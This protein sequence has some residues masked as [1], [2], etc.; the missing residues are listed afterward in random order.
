[1]SEQILFNKAKGV[2]RL[3]I[4]RPEVKNALSFAMCNE[5]VEIIGELQSDR[6]IRVLVLNAKGPDFTAGADLKDMS[7]A[8]PDD[9]Q[10]RGKMV[11]GKAREMAWPIFIGLHNIRQPI[12]ASVR[13]H[14][15]GAGAQFILSADLTVASQTL[16]LA[17]PQVNLAH[18]VDHGESYF[19]P[20]KIGM[21]R[22]MQLTLLAETLTAE[23]AEK[24]GLVNWVV[25]DDKLEE[26]T[27]EVVER[28]ASMAPLAA[29]HIKKLL[30]KSLD[31]TI[32]A[33]YAAEAKAL[34]KCAASEDFVEAMAAFQEKRAPV[35]KGK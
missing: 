28:L 19:L 11:A 34:A 5:L 25:S 30:L 22:A 8:L 29:R 32:D 9:P 31:N 6:D 24:Y 7:D 3:T 20:R 27:E 4:N 10:A 23:N 12:V 35:F 15:I 26:K 16:K 33:Q 17:M 14:A 18:P 1:M 13:G 21:A 2:A